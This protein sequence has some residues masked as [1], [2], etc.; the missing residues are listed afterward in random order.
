M[1][2]VRNLGFQSRFLIDGTITG[3]DPSHVYFAS[4]SDLVAYLHFPHVDLFDCSFFAHR[5]FQGAIS[6]SSLGQALTILILVTGGSRLVTLV[7]VRLVLI[8]SR[9]SSDLI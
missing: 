8:H 7:L 6:T 2:S 3:L 5:V 9:L 1:L 4:V